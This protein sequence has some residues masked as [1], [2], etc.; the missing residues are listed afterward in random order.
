MDLRFVE[1]CALRC[2]RGSRFQSSGAASITQSAN[3]RWPGSLLGPESEFSS[4]STWVKLG[5][6][7]MGLKRAESVLGSAS[8]A[9]TARGQPRTCPRKHTKQ[10]WNRNEEMGFRGETEKQSPAYFCFLNKSLHLERPGLRGSG[11]QQA[12]T[13]LG[14]PFG[15]FRWRGIN[16]GRDIV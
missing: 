14:F 10:L 3:F 5:V 13:G 16:A 1:H 6:N 4:H 15:L 12:T 7:P 8:R 11:A 2:E 9:D